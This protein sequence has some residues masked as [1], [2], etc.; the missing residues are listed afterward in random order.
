MQVSSYLYK[1]ITICLC[2]VKWVI[3]LLRAFYMFSYFNPKSNPIII[4]Q[5]KKTANHKYF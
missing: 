2:T 5:Q 1:C 3:F 4:E